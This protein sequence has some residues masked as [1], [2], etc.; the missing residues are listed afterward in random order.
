MLMPR[1]KVP[2]LSVPLL[3]GG[4]FDLA[5]EAADFGTLICFYRG[6]HCPICAKQLTD[7]DH[8]AADFAAKGIEVVAISM[9]GQER[10]K[11][12]ADKIGAKALRIGYDLPLAEARRWGLYVSGTR[13][14]TS[15]GVEEPKLFSEPGLFIVKPDQTLYFASVQSMP[16]ARPPFG[17]LISALDFAQKND[18]PAR[19][20]HAEA[21]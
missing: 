10:A 16:F 21:A 12:M 17:E 20:E 6:V 8:R 19:G 3:G 15:T 1:Q 14:V 18:Y 11:G 9:D 4:R 5:Q 7:L 2:A 13:G